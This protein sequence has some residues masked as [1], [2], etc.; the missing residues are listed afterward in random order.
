MSIS[1]SRSRTSWISFQRASAVSKTVFYVKEINLTY[2]L[3]VLVHVGPT[4]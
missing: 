3:L 2:A 4:R 1:F